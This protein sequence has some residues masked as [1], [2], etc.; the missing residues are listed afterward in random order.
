MKCYEIDAVAETIMGLELR[1]ESIGERAERA[2]VGRSGELAERHEIVVRPTCTFAPHR[3]L[4]RS[5]L[6]V[7]VVVAELTRNV[8]DLVGFGKELRGLRKIRRGVHGRLQG[9]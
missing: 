3:L 4:E 1:R 8:D 7:H 5:V 6:Q 9:R 2:V